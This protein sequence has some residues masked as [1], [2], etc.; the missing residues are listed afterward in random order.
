[1]NENKGGM[2]QWIKCLLHNTG[3]EFR[4]LPPTKEAWHVRTPALELGMMHGHRKILGALWHAVPR[5]QQT[6][7][8]V[9]APFSE[10]VEIT[11]EDPGAQ[12]CPQ[13]NKAQPTHV[14]K[15]IDYN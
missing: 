5:R 2:A 7:G 9:R 8:S 10:A 3:P 12:L 6:P 15:H 14:H 11:E 1:M 4:S 13:A